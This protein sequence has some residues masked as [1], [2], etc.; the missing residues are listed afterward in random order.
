MD[1]V[2]VFG[3]GR[4]VYLYLNLYLY[5]EGWFICIW[6]D[7]LFVFIFGGMVYLYLNLVGWCISNSTNVPTLGIE[8]ADIPLSLHSI[9][10]NW[11]WCF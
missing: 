10:S 2:F 8:E 3:F 11:W 1:G 5:L 6:R 9:K 7:D 4:M